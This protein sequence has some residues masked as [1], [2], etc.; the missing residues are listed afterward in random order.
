VGDAADRDDSVDLSARMCSY[1]SYELLRAALSTDQGRESRVTAARDVVA[2]V[3]AESGVNGLAQVA[4]QLSLKLADA[5][6]RIASEQRV[7]AVD[8][9][10]VWLV[11]QPRGTDV[12]AT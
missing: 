10:N 6:E 7:A 11:E 3:L 12:I 2:G 1:C 8:L 4:V 5:L 9:A